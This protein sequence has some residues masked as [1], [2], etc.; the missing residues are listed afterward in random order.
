[1]TIIS[2]IVD[3]A[4]NSDLRSRV[5]RAQRDGEREYCVHLQWG[6][7][8]GSAKLGE[9]GFKGPVFQGLFSNRQDRRVKKKDMLA[10]RRAE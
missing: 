7:G 2:L 9:L 1:M 6:L 4:T 10:N 8:F 3:D 5:G